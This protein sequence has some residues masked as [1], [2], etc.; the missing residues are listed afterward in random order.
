MLT[1]N[2]GRTSYEDDTGWPRDSLNSIAVQAVALCWLVFQQRFRLVVKRDTWRL[3]S[4]L[5]TASTGG[6]RRTG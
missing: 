5:S 1:D 3:Q 2:L 4:E 6:N